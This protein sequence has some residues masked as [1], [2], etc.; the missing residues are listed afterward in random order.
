M[1]FHDHTA[2]FAAGPGGSVSISSPV[3]TLAHHQ[4]WYHL[5][6]VFTGQDLQLFVN[7]RQFGGLPVDAAPLVTGANSRLE[8]AAYLEHEPHM[9]LGH[10]VTFA[11][12]YDEAL[13]AS[14]VAKRFSM[15]KIALDEGW[16]HPGQLHLSAGPFLRLNQD[17]SMQLLWETD[18]PT[19]AVVDWGLGA[20]LTQRLQ[21][22]ATSTRIQHATLPTLK[23]ATQY[24]YRIRATD[25]SGTSIDSGTLT[26]RTP[27]I[28]GQTT[29]I[30][31]IGA[32][33][34]RPHISEH[35]AA[36]MLPLR[37]DALIN[38]GP[39]TDGGGKDS[40]HLWNLE[41]F[42]GIGLISAQVPTIVLPGDGD[43]DRF[44]FDQYHPPAAAEGC[45]SIRCGDA[46]FFLLDTA[47]ATP[48]DQQ[49]AT[50]RA[51]LK[52]RVAASTAPWK[53]VCHHRPFFSSMAHADASPASEHE[54]SLNSLFDEL[55]I[56]LVLSALPGGYER[57]LAIRGGVTNPEGVIYVNTGGG[58]ADPISFPA[59]TPWHSSTRQAG[60]HFVL[61]EISPQSL[62]LTAH[63]LDGTPFDRLTIAK[64]TPATQR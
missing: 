36:Q 10:L 6:A 35:L 24:S 33:H 62:H 38:L 28:A 61:L 49:E 19:S 55:G 26:F 52:H 64:S 42:R 9:Q 8:I 25:P 32:A 59:S 53:I 46:E 23:P 1:G 18:R 16:V 39:L 11:R 17:Q 29:R 48:R 27:P 57:S 31:M 37:P 13:T 5:A 60:H 30:G 56:D 58:G 47:V 43:A 15:M 50:C 21:F 3:E 20:D 4:H 22:K 34:L 51:W 14:Q 7:G 44:W 63:G 2:L 40:K 54:T 12:L 45:S 41:Y